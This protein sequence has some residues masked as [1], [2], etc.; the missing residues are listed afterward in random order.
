LGDFNRAALCG[1]VLALYVMPV[2]FAT[3]TKVVN[4]GISFAAYG[5]VAV[6]ATHSLAGEMPSDSGIRG[7]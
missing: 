2:G 4:V 5:C 1:G 3:G 6:A 7:Y